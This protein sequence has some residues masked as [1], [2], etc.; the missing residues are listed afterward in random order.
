MELVKIEKTDTGYL[1][2]PNRY[3][4]WL[5][6]SS[7]LLPA[8]AAAFATDPDHYDIHSLKCV[9]DLGLARTVLKD[10]LEGLSVEILLGIHD[11]DRKGWDIR[12]SNVAAFSISVRDA[13]GVRKSDS[14]AGF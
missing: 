2:D 1:L 5:D 4:D 13:V 10:G 8:G 7:G 11:S 9:K 12:Y 3:L 6:E 14:V